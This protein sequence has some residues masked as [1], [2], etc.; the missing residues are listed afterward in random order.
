MRT[1]RSV[2]LTVTFVVSIGRSNR[3]SLTL[4][5]QYFKHG[6][7]LHV[8]LLVVNGSSSNLHFDLWLP[9]NRGVL[10]ATLVEFPYETPLFINLVY[11]SPSSLA[12]FLFGQLLD[13]ATHPM[14]IQLNQPLASTPPSFSTQA[15]FRSISWSYE[16]SSIG[17]WTS[18]SVHVREIGF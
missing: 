18:A 3:P 8:N 10:R 13:H 7:S 12:V 15:R 2:D 16:H 11:R 17:R 1:C 14:N 9:N 4:F 6:A 5:T